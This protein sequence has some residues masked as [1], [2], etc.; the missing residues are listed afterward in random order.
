MLQKGIQK[1]K[2]RNFLRKVTLFL[3]IF[4]GTFVI[5]WGVYTFFL[6][7]KSTTVIPITKSDVK[8]AGFSKGTGEDIDTVKAFCAH[9]D[10]SCSSINQTSDSIVITESNGSQIFLATNKDILRQLSSLQLTLNQLTIEGKQFKTLNFR[11]E[12]ITISF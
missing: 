3:G 12:K 4:L 10:I 1:R 9:Q 7:P 6:S 5:C 11:F 2:T 8:I